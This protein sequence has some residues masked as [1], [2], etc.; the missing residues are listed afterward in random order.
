MLQVYFK[1][2]CM[3]IMPDVFSNHFNFILIRFRLL[4]PLRDSQEAG[5]C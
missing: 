4:N 3:Q 1:E 5:R 2:R